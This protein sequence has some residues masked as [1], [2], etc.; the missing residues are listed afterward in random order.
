MTRVKAEGTPA[1]SKLLMLLGYSVRHKA[2]QLCKRTSFIN[3]SNE[4]LLMQT[5]GR[6]LLQ[7]DFAGVHRMGP[8]CEQW[9]IQMRPS[10]Q[11]ERAPFK[12]AQQGFAVHALC[13]L[14]PPHCS[15]HWR[16]VEAC[17]HSTLS[18]ADKVHK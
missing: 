9:C 16:A 17:M 2:W 13:I 1:L 5:A 8:L 4:P 11:A 10:N 18:A 7:P 14:L 15:I 12:F 6:E 3:T